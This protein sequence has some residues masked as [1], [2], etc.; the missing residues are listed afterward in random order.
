[1]KHLYVKK[2][3]IL[4]L[5]FFGFNH[6]SAQ[7][8]NLDSSLKATQLQLLESE[9]K[10]INDSLKMELM[11]Q[12]MQANSP[13]TFTSNEDDSIFQ[14]Q[15]LQEIASKK[16]SFSGIPVV[17]FEDTLFYIYTSL[18]PYS[19]E[20]RAHDITIKLMDLYEDRSFNK[21]SIKV[22]EF[23][24]L[25][26]ISYGTNIIT[27]VSLVDAMWVDMNQD[28]LALDIAKIIGNKID[29]YKAKNSFKNTVYKFGI[30]ALI[31]VLAF[32]IIYIVGK[33]FKYILKRVIH[34]E[35]AFLNGIKI[36]NYQLL[37]KQQIIFIGKKVL[38]ALQFFTT[39]VLLY[40]MVPLIFSI[41]PI[42]RHWARSLTNWLWE[43]F[44][45]LGN[46][47][48][49]YLPSLITIIIIVFIIRYVLKVLRFL[50]IEIQRG[51]LKIRNFYPE[52]AKPTYAILRFLLLAFGLILIFPHLPGSDSLA[53]KG[54][55][56]FLGV[57]FSIGSSSAIAN[58]IAGFVI[59]YMRPFN[60]GDWI[61]TGDTIGMV[62]EKN[63]LV[64]RLRTIDNE[65]ITVPNSSILNSHTV[66]YS[67]AGNKEGL[68]ISKDVTVNYDVNADL[69]EKLL[70]DAAT[71]T[72]DIA[73]SPSPFVFQK[74][75]DT[76]YATF[77]LKAYTFKPER[78]YHIHSD[79]YKNIMH[80]FKEHNIDLICSQF[81]TLKSHENHRI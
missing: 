74:N 56:V 42:T 32:S 10:R 69:V 66:N 35:R 77:Q 24:N 47:I 40:A 37:K 67:S 29:F 75:M 81:V 53:F 38:R 14:T 68:I 79:L 21:D 80:L 7:N 25:I 58:I 63:A 45:N 55:S 34:S 31:I 39:I 36:R 60:V 49:D 33:V 23:L 17:F 28:S 52:W 57:L 48:I 8:K 30:F 62:L 70:Q 76:M 2:I 18:G 43:P 6:L 64:T 20:K 41:F 19:P 1:M 50:A 61:K 5:L 4:T 65:E 73:N 16:L 13:K 72:P 26:N 54:V 51:A 44:R 46:A 71:N 59:T 78:M 27:S 9:K 3:W 12:Q 15:V 22:N 11:L